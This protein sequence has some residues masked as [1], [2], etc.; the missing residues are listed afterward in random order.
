MTHTGITFRNGK[1]TIV[2]IL[3]LFTFAYWIISQQ[4]NVYKSAPVGA[5]YELLWL[6][7]L[8]GLIILP[9]ISLLFWR[10]DTTQ[11][12]W[13]YLFSAGLPVLALILL[14]TMYK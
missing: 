7:M 2:I 10:K 3:S 12:R 14:L 1:R 11:W 8:L 6:P 5:V 4:I 9:V 13:L